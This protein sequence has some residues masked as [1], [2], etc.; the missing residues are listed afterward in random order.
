MAVVGNS[1]HWVTI[2]GPEKYGGF[3]AGSRP[4]ELL[5]MALTSCSAMDV[6]S[7]LR[8]KRVKLDDFSVEVEAEQ[9]AEHPK[10]FTDIKLHYILSGSNILPAD[11]ERAIELSENKYCSASIML[12]KS[13]N[14]NHDYTIV[15][16]EEE[17]KSSSA[18]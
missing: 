14:I 1:G 12:S 5:L 7:I 13:V 10:V 17:S 8:K 18:G 15:D 16:P 11:V 2:D 6:V 9:A 3:S 4:M